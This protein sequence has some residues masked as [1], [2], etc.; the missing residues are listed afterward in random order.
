MNR[1]KSGDRVDAR[2]N[3]SRI[4]AA[5]EQVFAERGPAGSTED[6]ARLAG[7]AV[8]TVFRHFPTKQ[9]LLHA[10]MKELLA[11]LGARAAELAAADRDGTALFAFFADL[12]AQAATRKSVLDLLADTGTV[13]DIDRPVRGF[14]QAIASMLDGA[15]RHGTARGDITRADVTA[16]LIS[17]TQ[18]ALRAGWS[19]ERQRRVLRVIFDG[20]APC[21][22]DT[23]RR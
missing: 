10:I 5:A 20:M 11:R 22:A 3:R 19:A 17:T 12:V 16:L 18:G 9:A 13:V 4:L 21:P 15:Q 1:P 8:G 14:D 23:G 7:V 6:I 2:R